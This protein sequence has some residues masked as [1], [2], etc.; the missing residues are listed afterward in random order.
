MSA[1][2]APSIPG[3]VFRSLAG[4]VAG[5][6][7]T[8]FLLIFLFGGLATTSGS[9]VSPFFVFLAVVMG[10]ITSL[11]TNNLGAF[12]FSLLD[13]EKY[14]NIRPVLKQIFTL[15]LFI[16][17]F[18]LPVYLV[19]SAGG[20]KIVLAVVILQLIL[21]A[22]ASIFALELS[23]TSERNLLSTYGITFG[24]L[25][26][27]IINILA[28]AIVDNLTVTQDATS[29]T[30]DSSGATLVVFML[31]PLTWFCFGFFTAFAEMLYRWIY[32]VWGKDILLNQNLV[33]QA[34]DKDSNEAEI[35]SK[36]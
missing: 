34:S 15:N 10:F 13:R 2:K 29:T 19:G 21:S 35:A 7:G 20:V 30:L 32:T 12:L 4:L 33:I 24:M 27:I 18:L 31:L 28:F 6:A 9:A 26:S 22:Q 3:L 14:P 11:V 16:F 25:V 17:L 1:P 36:F 23:S 8:V 5:V